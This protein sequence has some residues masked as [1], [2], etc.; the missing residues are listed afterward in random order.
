[1][2]EQYNQH[3]VVYFVCCIYKILYTKRH[4]TEYALRILCAGDVPFGRA[5]I[6]LLVM[7]NLLCC[8]NPPTL[9]KNVQYQYIQ[10]KL[11]VTESNCQ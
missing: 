10:W 1:M 7:E 2:Q 9:H 3:E 8:C 5:L 6:R 4:D 11:S